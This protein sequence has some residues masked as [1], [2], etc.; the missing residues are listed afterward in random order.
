MLVLIVYHMRAPAISFGPNDEGLYL[1]FFY[2]ASY[3]IAYDFPSYWTPIAHFS[4]QSFWTRCSETPQFHAV[5]FALKKSIK[6]ARD[7]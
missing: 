2:S 3:G 5:S 4:S 6:C 7:P 1:V